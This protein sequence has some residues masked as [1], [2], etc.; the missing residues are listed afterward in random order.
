MADKILTI[1]ELIKE[2]NKYKFTQLHIHHTW[3]P[4]HRDFNGKNHLALQQGMRNYHINTNGWGDIGHHLALM[5]DGKWVTGRP[6]NKTPASIKEWNTGALAVEM[7]GNFD[8]PGTGASNSSGYDKLDGKQK[9]SILALIKYY[10]GK[11]GFEG[12]KFHNEGPRVKKTCPG[13]SLNKAEMIRE[14]KALKI[15]SEDSKDHQENKEAEVKSMAALKRGDKGTEVKRLQQ[16]LI[17]LGYGEPMKDYGADGSFGPITEEA[18]KLFQKANGLVVD[19]KAGPKTRGKISELLQHKTT[20][21]LASSM[22]MDYKREY[23]KAKS[24][25]DE[26]KRIV[27]K[28]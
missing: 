6:F 11:Y 22:E 25:L 21:I 26:I 10:G 20:T 2:L 15:G 19:G 8:K 14:A 12:I 9:D 28:P 1:T 3:K 17:I 13:T 16:D 4:T 5:P 23:S 7:V 27:A 18:V 24:K